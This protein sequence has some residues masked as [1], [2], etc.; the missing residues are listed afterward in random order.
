MLRSLVSLVLIMR[1]P[2]LRSNNVHDM[3]RLSIKFRV[4]P[5]E[6]M[7]NATSFMEG[8]EGMF[9]WPFPRSKFFG[10]SVLL[11]R[12]AYTSRI[13]SG[14]DVYRRGCLRRLCTE[15]VLL[16]CPKSTLQLVLDQERLKL[17]DVA[18]WHRRVRIVTR[19]L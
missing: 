16:L 17:R 14:S 18:L 4:Q 13:A 6:S 5:F 2:P 19:K 12:Q 10:R 8:I 7:V 3:F 15:C 9:I 1:P 11:H